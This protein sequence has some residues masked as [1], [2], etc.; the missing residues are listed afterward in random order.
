MPDVECLIS[1]LNNGGIEAV[2][3][4]TNIGLTT[5]YRREGPHVVFSKLGHTHAHRIKQRM[6]A[7]G[8]KLQGF[9]EVERQ[10]L[11]DFYSG[12]KVML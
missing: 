6:F 9:L 5:Y 2:I 12:K 8:C 4:F 1:A 11:T 7:S 10:M 3:E